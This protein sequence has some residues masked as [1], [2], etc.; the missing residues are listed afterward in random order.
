MHQSGELSILKNFNFCLLLGGKAYEGI[1][2]FLGFILDKLT[3]PLNVL[4]S[5]FS[6]EQA[7]HQAV[8]FPAGLHLDHAFNLLWVS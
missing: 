6:R 2:W 7:L 5:P 8:P 3:H 4:Q 1:K